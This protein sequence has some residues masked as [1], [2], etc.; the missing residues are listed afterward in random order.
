MVNTYSQI[1]IQIVFAVQ[2]RVALIDYSWEEHLY[3]Y[4]TGIIQNNGQK[5]ISINGMPDH[6]HFFIGMKPSCNLSE[7]VRDIKKSSNLYVNNERFTQYRFSWQEGY[8]AFSYSHNQVRNVANYIDNQ[9]KHHTINTFKS[10]YIKL[11]E[12]NEIDYKDEYV[13]EWIL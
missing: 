6:I 8:G 12:F 2:N 4:I 7:L 10:E 13:F 1:Y 11:L 5:M 3:R 9:K